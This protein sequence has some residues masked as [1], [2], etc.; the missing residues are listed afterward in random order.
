[1]LYCHL[2][3]RDMPALVLVDHVI[4]RDT[5]KAVR[6]GPLP[7]FLLSGRRVCNA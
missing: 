3:R 4:T 5:R 2:E 6:R 1:V 7:A